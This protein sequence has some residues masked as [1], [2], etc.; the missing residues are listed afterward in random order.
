MENKKYKTK[1]LIG[2]F[3]PY[4]KPYKNVLLLDLFC[5]FLTTGCDLILPM[6][7]RF[8]ANKGTEDLSSITVQLIASLAGVYLVLRII[9]AIANYYMTRIGHIMG[10]RIETDMRKDA[11]EIGRAHV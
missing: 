5:A 9:D 6:I 7:L 3:I 10:A 2:R 4:F 11:F 1:D 8:L